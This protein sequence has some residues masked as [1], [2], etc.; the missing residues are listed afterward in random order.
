MRPNLKLFGLDLSP[1]YL[2]HEL[3]KNARCNVLGQMHRVLAPGGTLVIEDSAQP[4]DAGKVT[5]FWIDS[6]KSSTSPS[7]VTT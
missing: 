6:A 2:F 5:F 4:A 1:Y 7:I 3:P